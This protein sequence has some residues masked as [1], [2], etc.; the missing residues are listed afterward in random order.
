MHADYH[1]PS[2]NLSRIDFAHM[3][4]VINSAARAVR[5]LADGQ[6]PVWNPGGR[7]VPQAH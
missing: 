3:T 1:Q 6:L 2:D 4:A 7:P 5:L